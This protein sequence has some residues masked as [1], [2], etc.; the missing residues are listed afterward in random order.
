MEVYVFDALGSLKITLAVFFA[1]LLV[2]HVAFVMWRRSRK[3]WLIIDYAWLSVAGL[4][5]ISATAQV[6]Q[7]RA[8]WEHNMLKEDIPGRK[9]MAFNNAMIYERIYR[10]GFPYDTW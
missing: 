1:A 10:E 4:A 7:L 2:A 6:R 3:F 8:T 9:E 5:L